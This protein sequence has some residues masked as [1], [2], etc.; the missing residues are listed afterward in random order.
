MRLAFYILREHFAPFLYSFAILTFLFIID[1]LMKLLD[2][3]LSKGLDV[4]VI[5][6]MF[7]LNLAWMLA[8]SIPMSILVA[9]LMA[10]GRLAGDNEITACRSAGV[11]PLRL[12]W[13]VTLVSSLIMFSLMAFNHWVLPEANHRAAGLKADIARKKPPAL[14]T[15]G[16]LIKDFDGYRIWVDSIN[17]TNDSL[18]GVKIYYWERNQP[19]RYMYSKRASMHFSADARLIFINLVKGENHFVDTK[20]PDRY[21]RVQFQNQQLTLTNVD[22]TL[23]RQDREYRSDREMSV[24]Q[25]MEVVERARQEQKRLIEENW[26]FLFGSWITSD[27]ALKKDTTQLP[28][29]YRVEETPWYREYPVGPVR[30][31]TLNANTRD[32]LNGVKS[33]V[34]RLES[35]ESEASKFLVEIHKKF[36]IPVACLVFALVGGSL[37][38]MAKKGGMGM[39]SILCMGPFLIYWVFLLQGEAMADRL[40]I[41]PWL[42]MWLPNIL[43]GSIS[44]LLLYRVQGMRK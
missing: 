24:T 20:N 10:F 30:Y 3:I 40:L 22:A 41:S 33:L 16:T 29:T 37:G 23:Y 36:S 4:F 26:R 43:V 12:L 32:I 14:I 27:S 18:Y 9:C 6:E 11:S 39:A 15:P 38:M 25:M 5:L 44:L 19:P 7:V 31:H 2:S 34:S 17:Y 21:I 35:E 1:F 13:P 8:L 42:A 28:S